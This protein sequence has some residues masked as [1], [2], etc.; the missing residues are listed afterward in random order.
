MP[1][2][3][4][5]L[6][7]AVTLVVSSLAGHDPLKDYFSEVSLKSLGPSD[8]DAVKVAV[9]AMPEHPILAQV[10]AFVKYQEP[11]LYRKLEKYAQDYRQ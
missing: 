4:L 7:A 9:K 10:L 2:L 1:K 5:V 6:I 11:R 8:F 3:V